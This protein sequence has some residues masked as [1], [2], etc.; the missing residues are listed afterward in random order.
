MSKHN[1]N[2]L[3]GLIFNV[4]EPIYY[5]PCVSPLFHFCFYFH[6]MNDILHY[7]FTDSAEFKLARVNEYASWFASENGLMV[8]ECYEGFSLC[9]CINPVTEVEPLGYGL[10]LCCYF[11]YCFVV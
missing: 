1:Y 7:L 11:R 4:V 8:F 3:T 10:V 6:F 9:C 5:V 2:R